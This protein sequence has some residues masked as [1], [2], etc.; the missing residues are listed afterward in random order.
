MRLDRFISQHTSRKQAR[1][2]IACG[3]VVV[4]EEVIRDGEYSISPF[5]TVT[6]N[7]QL[8]QRNTARYFMLN[9]PRGYVS[10]TSDTEHSTVIELIKEPNANQLHIAGRLDRNSSGLLI[11]TNDGKWSR[12][13]TEPNKKTPKTYLIET[14][15]PIHPDTAA[16]FFD[17]IYFAYE[18]ITT[19]PVTLEQLSSHSARLTLFEGRYH[20]IKRMFGRF[21]NPVVSIHRE[22]IGEIKLDPILKPGEYRALSNNETLSINNPPLRVARY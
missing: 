1:L 19:K 9:K 3:K 8:L 6:M 16:M 13:L 18:N 15:N 2:S 14:K 10:A 7:D 4:N 22:Q 11:L 17:G 20:Q 5:C 12:V 21:R